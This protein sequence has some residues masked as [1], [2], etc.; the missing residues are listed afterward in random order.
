MII[1]HKAQSRYLCSQKPQ[2]GLLSL[3]LVSPPLQLS[4]Y[5][6]CL[7][8]SQH[9]HT[10][11]WLAV[12]GAVSAFLQH[13]KMISFPCLSLELWSMAILKNF[14]LTKWICLSDL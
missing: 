2:L 3:T 1:L 12:G 10:E 14:W 13:G 11:L 6:G 9:R 5:T 4:T 8:L 7:S